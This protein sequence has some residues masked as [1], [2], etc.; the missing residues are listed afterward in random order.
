MSDYFDEESTFSHTQSS[1]LSY[2]RYRSKIES[3]LENVDDKYQC[4]KN[5]KCRLLERKYRD[6]HL[7][8]IV[9]GFGLVCGITLVLSWHYFLFLILIAAIGV[10]EYSTFADTYYHTRL[11]VMNDLLKDME[12]EKRHC[13]CQCEK[14]KETCTETKESREEEQTM[15]TEESSEPDVVDS[16][17]EKE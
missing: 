14:T 16:Q 2:S 17:I 5:A 3:K 12:H 15:V 11:E 10:Y 13:K 1:K 4:L 9:A 7:A 6:E 8:M